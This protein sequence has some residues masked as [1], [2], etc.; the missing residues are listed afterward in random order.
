MKEKM[1]YQIYIAGKI[2]GAGIAKMRGRSDKAARYLERNNW[3]VVNPCDI[4]RRRNLGKNAWLGIYMR[5][6]IVMRCFCWIIGK[7]HLGATIEMQLA[8][9]LRKP[10]I[11]QCGDI[12]GKLAPDGEV[13][14]ICP[15]CVLDVSSRLCPC[16]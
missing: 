3:Q 10:V 13:V 7:R 14:C 6:W 12:A 9:R 15:V 11:Y 1:F 5:Y 16:L 4:P 8:L 2:G